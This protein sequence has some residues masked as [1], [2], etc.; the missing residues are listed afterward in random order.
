MSGG[1]FE[2]TQHRITTLA[3]DVLNAH[4]NLVEND[5]TPR[6]IT[7]RVLTTAALLT[8]AAT[9]THALDLWLSCDTEEGEFARVYD[10]QRS[11]ILS[12]MTLGLLS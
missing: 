7:D 6:S 12:L 10:E 3:E 2:Y 8:A 5:E 11:R 1:R 9:I 4:K